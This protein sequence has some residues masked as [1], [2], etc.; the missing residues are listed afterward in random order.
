[1]KAESLQ[2]E[3]VFTLSPDRKLVLLQEETTYQAAMFPL[4]TVKSE[5]TGMLQIP[6]L[7]EHIQPFTDH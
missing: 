1:M 5:E 7:S 6:T 2:N 3:R 4:I